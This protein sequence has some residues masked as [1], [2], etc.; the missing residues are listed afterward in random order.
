MKKVDRRP[1]NLTP[2]TAALSHQGY[3][4]LAHS[5]TKGLGLLPLCKHCVLKDK[6]PEYSAEEGAVCAPARAAQ[7]RLLG[8]LLSLEQ[9]DPV[10]DLPLVLE[11]V[12]S[13]IFLQ[14]VDKYVTEAGIFLPGAEE[15]YLEW[16]PV[17]KT[18]WTC[19]NSMAKISDKLGLNPVARARLKLEGRLSKKVAAV[20]ALE[21]G[22]DDD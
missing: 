19:A 10:Q 22:G 5:D 11:Y 18:R 21:A 8:Q 15:G 2:Q 17:L 12:K 3:R 13:A 20:L 6:C 16:Q 14:I 1:E 4:F 9:I 7:E